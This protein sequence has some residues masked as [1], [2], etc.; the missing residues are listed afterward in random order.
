M[1]VLHSCYCA[2]QPLRYGVVELCSLGEQGQSSPRLSDKGIL[3]LA[4]FHDV[5]ERSLK[6]KSFPSGGIISQQLSS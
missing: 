4:D 3:F 2:F 6:L 5:V 1:D